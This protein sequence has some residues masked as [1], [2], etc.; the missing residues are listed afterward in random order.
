MLQL[1][2]S[3]LSLFF[4]QISELALGFLCCFC[5]FV[6][7]CVLSAA[8][9]CVMWCSI[10]FYFWLSWLKERFVRDI[11]KHLARNKQHLMMLT[12]NFCCSAPCKWWLISEFYRG[13]RKL[14]WPVLCRRSIWRCCIVIVPGRCSI[15]CR[16]VIFLVILT[17]SRQLVVRLSW[18][19]AWGNSFVQNCTKQFGRGWQLLWQS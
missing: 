6:S 17:L 9:F 2:P 11:S 12:A 18:G 13:K 5:M 19:A 10:V 7:I 1:L 3:L 16:C 4:G 14:E 8:L 15:G